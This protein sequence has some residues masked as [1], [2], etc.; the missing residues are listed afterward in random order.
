M[1]KWILLL[2]LLPLLISCRDISNSSSN[3]NSE[4][5]NEISEG[6]KTNLI[7]FS[8]F[9]KSEVNAYRISS[10]PELVEGPLI[11]TEHETDTGDIGS[12]K[13]ELSDISGDEWILVELTKQSEFNGRQAANHRKENKKTYTLA[14]AEEWRE[15]IYISPI[16][17][18]A[19]RYTESW[20][21]NVSLSELENRL[22]DI[23]S[24]LITSDNDSTDATYKNIIS[25]DPRERSHLD[26][27]TFNY[28]LLFK[29]NGF[30]DG[31]RNGTEDSL[32]LNA[33][34][35]LFLPILSVHL[36]E[37][38]NDEVHVELSVFGRGE[39]SSDKFGLRAGSE[40]YK[41]EVVSKVYLNDGDGPL[42]F[43]ATPT[44][45]TLID[46]WSGCDRVSTDLR[47]CYIDR[48]HNNRLIEAKFAYKETKITPDFID[49]SNAI[50]SLQGSTLSVEVPRKE[51]TLMR[52]MNNISHGKYLTALTD[53]GPQILRVLS[54]NKVDTNSWLLTVEKASLTDVIEQGTAIF[55]RGL[56]YGDLDLSSTVLGDGNGVIQRKSNDSSLDDSSHDLHVE[57][58]E[59][60]NPKEATFQLR[61]GRATSNDYVQAQSKTGDA[62]WDVGDE[63]IKTTA[64]LSFDINLDFGASYGLTKGLEDFR[65]IPEIR[66]DAS[67]GVGATGELKTP[68]D[69]HGNDIF[70]KKLGTVQFKSIKFFVGI[71]PVYITPKISFYVG[72]NGKVKSMMSVDTSYISTVRAGI[73][74]N[75]RDG[76]STVRSSDSQ[77]SPLKPLVDGE[78]SMQ[79]YISA[80]PE[81]MLYDAMGPRLDL[82]ANLRFAAEQTLDQ[83]CGLGVDYGL[84]GGFSGGFAWTVAGTNTKFGK[85]LG[86]DTFKAK[87]NFLTTEDKIHGGILNGCGSAP[88]VMKVEGERI[89]D[90]VELGSN[91]SI[92]YQMAISNDGDAPM[93]WSLNYTSDGILNVSPTS[94][95]ISPGEQQIVLVNITNTAGLGIGL[96]NNRISFNNKY[97][98]GIGKTGI[99]STNRF[100]Q[101]N[102]VPKSIPKPSIDE[103]LRDEE[104]NTTLDVEWRVSL[105][106]QSDLIGFRVFYTEDSTLMDL[107]RNPKP[108]DDWNKLGEFSKSATQA[109]F[110]DMPEDTFYIIVEAFGKTKF[111]TV[112]SVVM[113]IPPTECGPLVQDRYQIFG[114][115]CQYVRD[116]TARLEWQRYSFGQGWDSKEKRATGQAYIYDHFAGQTAPTITDSDGWRIPK[117]EE[118][119]SIVYCSSKIAVNLVTGEEWP[120][121]IGFEGFP[122]YT[123]CKTPRQSPSLISDVF[124]LDWA[125]HQNGA[126]FYADR[127]IQPEDWSNPNVLGAVDFTSGGISDMSGHGAFRLVR[128]L[129]PDSNEGDCVNN[130]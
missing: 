79:G 96:Y 74:Y 128:C 72:V 61:I 5:K 67:L 35:N 55:K 120:A 48:V 93:P 66:S 121:H 13:L 23:A 36:P 9:S 86:V 44:S 60:E 56:T 97:D 42:V 19:W 37:N 102:I 20:I 108:S 78:A 73:I 8:E 92:N 2:A 58:V 31:I 125:L 106:D 63:A 69:E 40:V 110:E 17:D 95:T 32:L 81:L 65:F 122:V 49:A 123:A 100:V 83:S 90:T 129:E 18:I 4:D 7:V 105:E 33:L 45:E 103:A 28:D 101:I 112:Q 107:D 38:L 29:E 14:R 12:F 52:S 24:T 21:G 62:N 11:S 64:T 57:L 27:L 77:W 39:V 10:I 6:D 84:W 59:P 98:G 71:V 130:P 22:N 85:A 50:S 68:T 46:S 87:L 47:K 15:G 127:A 104:D 117:N 70:R 119:Q 91:K 116:I 34:D 30:V 26:S 16:S 126:Y 75:E 88:A 25:F 114:E 94:G 43:S 76:W 3:N 80:Q 99:G 111:Q 54:T 41:G 124:S 51:L 113:E 89:S 115:D 1:K 82:K 53:Q 118:L 109:R